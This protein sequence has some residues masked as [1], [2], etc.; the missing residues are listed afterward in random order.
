MIS[1]NNGTAA[2]LKNQMNYIGDKQKHEI[3]M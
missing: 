1:K 3:Y 2:E